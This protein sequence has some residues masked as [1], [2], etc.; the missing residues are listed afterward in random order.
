MANIE[1]IKQLRADTGAGLSDIKEALE[2]SKDDY[3]A[4]KSYL[5]KKGI[6]KADKRADREA[7]QGVIASYIHTTNKIGVLVEVNSET[8]FVARSEDFQNFGKNVAMQICAMSPLYLDESEIPANIRQEFVEEV[9]NDPKFTGKPE[10]IRN[11][12]VDAKMKT[13]AEEYCLL[14]QKFF[15]DSSVSIE[16]MMK[17]LSGKV[18]EAIRIKR[19]VRFE[20]G[21]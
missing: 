2:I 17:V 21:A 10:E 8:D 9:A 7:N 1:L 12:I 3:E 15:K 14:K 16:E 18:G 5:A 6:A 4:A 13:Y 20:V 19:F 11:N